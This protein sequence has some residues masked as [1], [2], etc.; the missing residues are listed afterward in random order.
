MKQIDPCGDPEAGPPREW[1]EEWLASEAAGD[2]PPW[3]VPKAPPQAKAPEP[4]LPDA[5]KNVV[6]GYK[7]GSR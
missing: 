2:M 5:V 3:R 6:C 7:T 4:E 1:M